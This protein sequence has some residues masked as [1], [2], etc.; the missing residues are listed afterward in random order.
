MFERQCGQRNVHRELRFKSMANMGAGGTDGKGR[1]LG[2]ERFFLGGGGFCPARARDEGSVRAVDLDGELVPHR[3]ERCGNRAGL[4]AGAVGHDCREAGNR[5]RAARRRVFAAFK[6]EKRAKR[7]KGEAAVLRAAVP[8]RAIFVFQR[9]SAARI[10][11]QQILALAIVSA[12][13]ERDVALTSLNA[14]G[15]DTHG[16]D[17]RGFFAHEGARGTGNA[18]HDGNVAGEQI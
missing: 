11:H 13:D 10:E 12:T 3:F 17:A 16:I 1:V 6:N 4:T 18:V 7:S 9:V 8:H 14:S 5:R 2:E 15:R